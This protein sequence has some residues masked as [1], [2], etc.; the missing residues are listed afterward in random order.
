MD[1]FYIFA[2]SVV[3]RAQRFLSAEDGDHDQ[4]GV[5]GALTQVDYLLGYT[6]DICDNLPE[7]RRA[8]ELFDTL[9]DCSSALRLRLQ[10]DEDGTKSVFALTECT[11]SYGRLFIPEDD[12]AGLRSEGFTVK[13]IARFYGVGVTTVKQR[14]A[15]AGLNKKFSTISDADLDLL[16]AGIL[17][18]FPNVGYRYIFGQLKTGGLYIQRRRILSSLRRIDPYGVANRYLTFV[19]RRVYSNPG[20]NALW[21]MDGN[22]KLVRWG[23]VIHGIIDGYSR[24]IIS[25]IVATNNR[26]STVLEAFLSG[27][28]EWGAPSRVRS[29]CG[30]ENFGVARWMEHYMGPNRASIIMG[31]SVH[32]QRIERLWRDLG[33]VV[34]KLF[35]SVFIHM[36]NMGILDYTNPRDMMILHLV[37]LDR[38]QDQLN[39]FTEFFNNHKL[40]TEHERS[41]RQLFILGC[42]E[43]GLKGFPLQQ[44]L[45]AG[46]ELPET[47]VDAPQDFP[48]FIRNQVAHSRDAV[49]VMD[50]ISSFPAEADF[51]RANMD[52]RASDGFYGINVFQAAKELLEEH[53]H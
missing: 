35:R 42:H 5:D 26:A 19:P 2:D 48:D 16:I 27:A 38:I 14:L 43:K 37:Y 46:D 32:N 49:P 21:H 25:L 33:R 11:N 9:I 3:R 22:H 4:D 20:P 50:I 12:L 44:L 28:E 7:E 10:E 39:Q 34:I 6:R 47:D 31:P 41:P 45:T 53:F 40:R 18:S 8:Q 13:D 1:Q 29:D 23:F 15:E 36:E 24:T 52:V 17:E 51:I 30:G